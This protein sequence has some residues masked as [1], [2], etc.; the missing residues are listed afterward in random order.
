MNHCQS[1]IYKKKRNVNVQNR[2]VIS[3]KHSLHVCLFGSKKFNNLYI[4]KYT[5]IYEAMLINGCSV[6][7]THFQKKDVSFGCQWS[8]V[9]VTHRHSPRQESE[10]AHHVLS[11]PFIIKNVYLNDAR[12]ESK[13]SKKRSFLNLIRKISE[14]QQKLGFAEGCQSFNGCSSKLTKVSNML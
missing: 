7:L 14:C 5:L 12:Q 10:E 2:E 8:R 3:I 13:A 9:C 11:G 1:F 4:T 6:P